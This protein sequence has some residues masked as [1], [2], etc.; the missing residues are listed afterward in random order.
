MKWVDVCT[1]RLLICHPSPQLRNQSLK[2]NKEMSLQGPRGIASLLVVF[3]H[4]ARA[5]DEDLFNPTS[6]EGAPPRLMQYPILRI[7][8]QGRIGVTI[9]SLVTGYV[10]ALKPI[11]QCRAGDQNAMFAGIAKSA[12]RRLPR[13][14]LP[15]TIATTLI[16]LF[17]QFGVFE[18][19]N[20]VTSWWLNYTSPNMTPYI[21]EAIKTLLSNLITTWT[22]S[23]NIYDNNQWTLLPLLKGAMLVYIMC[24]AT[25]YCKT[26]YRMMIEL[27]L[28]VYYYISNDC[29]SSPFAEI[30]QH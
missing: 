28:F 18:V 2:L 9:F 8:V 7:L 16:W 26:R 4:I 13:L 17:C 19:G 23:W 1:D 22:K 6:I 10:C 29:E 15:T 21:G 3:T 5:F 24:F 14:V 30:G 25:A 12:F 27:G 11:R 20:R